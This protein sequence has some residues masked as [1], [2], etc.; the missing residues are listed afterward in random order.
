M[1]RYFFN[2]AGFAVLC[3]ILS[4]LCGKKIKPQRI[5]EFLAKRRKEFVIE[6][7][8]KLCQELRTLAGLAP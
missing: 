7:R 3:A 2:K 6:S 5:A 4:V 8:F 1:I